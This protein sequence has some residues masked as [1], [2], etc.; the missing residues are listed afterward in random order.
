VSDDSRANGEARD[1]LQR[2][3]GP[4]KRRALL[5]C[6]ALL[7]LLLAC[8][9]KGPV[10]PPDLARPAPLDDLQ[11]T[12]EVDAI[13]LSWARPTRYADGTRMT[14]LGEF[15]VERATGTSPDFQIIALL[16]VT[17][18]DRFRQI[19]RFRFADRGV[20]EAE[21]YRYRVVSSTLDGYVSAPSNAVE[22]V[23]AAAATPVSTPRPEGRGK[24]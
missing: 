23:R 10:K 1:A 8:G 18:Q 13:L 14:D 11:A 20:V 16:P 7:P 22:I 4:A 15:R 3:R 12:N 24:R 5:L 19:K 21:T 2:C 17:D 6:L 9:R